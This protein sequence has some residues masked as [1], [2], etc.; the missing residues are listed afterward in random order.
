MAVAWAEFVGGA[1]LV[2]GL[3]TRFAALGMIVI[4]VGAI[5]MV[6]STRG[7]IGKYGGWEFNFVLL[8]GCLALFI[9]GSGGCAVDHL[10]RVR[11]KKPEKEAALQ[12]VG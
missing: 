3:F 11:E 4:Q 8:A 10:F 2:L 7:F 1:A 5:A 12:P 9:L 6:T